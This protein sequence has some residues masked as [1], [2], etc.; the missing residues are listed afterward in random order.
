MKKVLIISNNSGGGH[1]HTAGTL[2]QALTQYGWQPEVVSIY[3]EIFPDYFN[4]LG[5]EGEA[6]YNKLVLTREMT[7]FVYRL[8]FICAYYLIMVPHRQKLAKRLAEFLAQ[9]QPDLVISLIPGLNQIIADSVRQVEPPI[10]FAILQ[11]DLF[12]F[13]EPFWLTPKGSWFVADDHTYTIVGTDEAYQQVCSMFVTDT[14]R[15]FKLSGTLINPCF[16]EKPQFDIAAERRILGLASD[17]PVGLFLYGGFAPH[18]VLKAAKAL[19]RLGSEA[20]FIFICGK[21]EVLKHR[22]EA[23]AT[24]YNKVVVGYTSQVP[25]YMHLSDFLIGKPGPGTIMEGLAANLPL[26]MDISNV[27]IHESNNIAWVERYGFGLSFN[28]TTQLLARIEE[29]S[30]PDVYDPLK[31][32]VSAYQNRAVLEILGIIE[33]IM[34]HFQARQAASVEPKPITSERS[35]PPFGYAQDKPQIRTARADRI[36]PHLRMIRSSIKRVIFKGVRQ[37]LRDSNDNENSVGQT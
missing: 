23:V 21:N 11:T 9:K 15:V 6:F 14:E 25:Y 1:R 37:K 34:D 24:R 7:G 4:I 10:P 27:I 26:L 13:H 33:T 32:R 31:R 28:D 16:F 22:L 8:F 35:E 36:A 2:T 29:L 18:R 19:N 3:Q 30:R 5:I 20:Q 12:E 17:R